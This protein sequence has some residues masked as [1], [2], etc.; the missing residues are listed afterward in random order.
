VI[1]EQIRILGLTRLALLHD[2]LR[3]TRQKDIGT[4]IALLRLK[5]ILA[6]R[7]QNHRLHQ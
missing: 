7:L 2:L 6:D 3:S 4:A 5:Y 1:T